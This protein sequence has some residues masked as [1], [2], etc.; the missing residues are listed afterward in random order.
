MDIDETPKHLMVAWVGGSIPRPLHATYP[1]GPPSN[2]SRKESATA[3]SA[4][5]CV[6]GVGLSGGSGANQMSGRTILDLTGVR[7]PHRVSY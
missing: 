2:L 1:K 7:S 6:R 3:R 4:A 5:P